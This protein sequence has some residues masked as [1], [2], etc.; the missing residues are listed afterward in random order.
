MSFRP[1]QSMIVETA[2]ELIAAQVV[3]LLVIIAFDVDHTFL[4]HCAFSKELCELEMS[5]YHEQIYYYRKYVYITHNL[6]SHIHVRVLV[7]LL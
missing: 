1:G 3:L 6:D 2:R 5:Y 7:I 4:F